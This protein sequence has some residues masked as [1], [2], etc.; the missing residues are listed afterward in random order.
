MVI[1][2]V[3]SFSPCFRENIEENVAKTVQKGWQ[4]VKNGQKGRTVFA[5]FFLIFTPKKEQKKTLVII[6]VIL[7]IYLSIF[8]I[9]VLVCKVVF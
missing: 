6:S 7:Y 3:F 1:I 5:T 4:M 8:E 2:S 9:I